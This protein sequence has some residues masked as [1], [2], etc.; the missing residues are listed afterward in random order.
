M[1]RPRQ[2]SPANGAFLRFHGVG[3]EVGADADVS[4]AVELFLFYDSFHTIGPMVPA[5]AP[6]SPSP[7][8]DSFAIGISSPAAIVTISDPLTARLAVSVAPA[9]PA[10]A[11]LLPST[12]H[13]ALVREDTALPPQTP[14]TPETP[15]HFAHPNDRANYFATFQSIQAEQNVA[16]FASDSHPA[17]SAPIELTVPAPVLGLSTCPHRSRLP[18]AG[19]A[20]LLSGFFQQRPL[21]A[22]ISGGDSLFASDGDHGIGFAHVSGPRVEGV[23]LTPRLSDFFHQSAP[24]TAAFSPS[25]ELTLQQPVTCAPLSTFF[26]TRSEWNLT[27]QKSPTFS[28][29]FFRAMFGYARTAIISICPTFLFLQVAK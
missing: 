3:A 24:T 4:K 5:P 9:I 17:P 28:F 27:L 10:L 8:Y 19:Q 15:E 25:S 26:H 22:G 21:N 23:P 7:V 11:G 14:E 16:P 20:T 1:I 18:G 13:G 6:P 12:V 2:R 29:S